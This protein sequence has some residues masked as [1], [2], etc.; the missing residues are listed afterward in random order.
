MQ[1]DE[2]INKHY[3]RLNE[4]DL[5]IWNYVSNH[6]KE[7]EKLA[8]DQLA[9]KCNVSRTTVLRFSQKLSLKGYG[10]L[11]VLLKLDNQRSK[12]TLNDVDTVCRSYQMVADHIRNL[13]CTSLFEKMD[14]AR[15]IYVYGVGMIQSSI[16][17]EL[18]R[19]FMSAGIMIY[20][21]SEYTEAENIFSIVNDQDLFIMISISGENESILDLTKKLKVLNVPILSI[22]RLQNNHL[23]QL[24][25]Y[26]LYVQ[27]TRFPCTF[28]TSEYES[29]TAYF[30]LIEILFIK[31][32]QYKTN[33][34]KQEV[35]HEI[36]DSH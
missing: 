34:I 36:R 11:K 19:I 14:S 29:L 10:E 2:L 6:R 25:N 20:S 18:K 16:K 33:Q 12:E 4:N 15:N 1:L 28:M 24:S 23:S 35:H 8:I 7:C 31:Y 5:H 17:K 3:R 32:N 27:D 21:L 13:D 30:I 9:Y 22:T 26:N